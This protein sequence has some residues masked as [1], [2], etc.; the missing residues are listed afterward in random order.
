MGTQLTPRE[1]YERDIEGLKQSIRQ[2][3]Q[4]LSNS[5]LELTPQDRAVIRK[6]I[7]ALQEYLTQEQRKF[8][9]GK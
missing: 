3:F 1:K 2:M 6:G 7:H 4:D 9:S 5:T 8:E